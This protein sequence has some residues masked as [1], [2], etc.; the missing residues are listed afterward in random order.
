MIEKESETVMTDIDACFLTIRLVTAEKNAFLLVEICPYCSL[1]NQASKIF[2]VRLM[3][4][5]SSYGLLAKA[6]LES[7]L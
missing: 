6:N 5:L 3:I 1:A 4:T 7:I 2:E